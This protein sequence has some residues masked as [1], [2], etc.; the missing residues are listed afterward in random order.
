MQFSTPYEGICKRVVASLID[1]RIPF[2]WHGT[3][4]PDGE[5]TI[6]IESHNWEDAFAWLT[7]SEDFN[8]QVV[9]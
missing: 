3:T 9:E 8:L 1:G 4:D 7:D 2:R 5:M 6:K